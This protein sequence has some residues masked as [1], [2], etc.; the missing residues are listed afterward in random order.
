MT[1]Q[2]SSLA[3]QVVVVTGASAG[4]GRATARLFGRQGAKVALLAR[5]EAGLEAAAR[6]VELAGG[7]AL[8]VPTDMAHYHEVEEAAERVERELGDIDVWLNV[9]F[10]SVFARFIDVKPEEFERTT[11]VTYLGYVWGTRVALERMRGRDRGVIVQAGSALAYRSIP[12]QSAYC[13]AKHAIKGF[14]E[15]LRTE[16]LHD[17]SGVKITMVQLPALNTPQFD[18]VLSRLRRHPQPVPPI[19]QPEVAAHALLYA[20]QHPQRREFWVGGS[21]AMTVLAQKLAPAL[22]DRY[23]ARTGMN[24]QQ[25]SGPPTGIA[26]LWEAADFERDFGAHGSFDQRAKARSLQ[27]WASQ[28]RGLLVVAGAA[29]GIAALRAVTKR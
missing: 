23:L 7:T 3:G 12:L 1:D 26:N 28:H 14:T 13:G 24:S 18:W 9:A 4:V 20:A 16:L 29:T 8:A 6:E 27:L 15:S 11:R 19:F 2:R 10:S 22:L 5:G 17:S 25:T 21:T